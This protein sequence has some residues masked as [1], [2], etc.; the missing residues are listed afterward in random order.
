[1]AHKFMAPLQVLDY[2]I[3]NRPLADTLDYEITPHNQI[4]PNFQIPIPHLL[5]VPLL[6]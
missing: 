3:Y 5:L 2:C 4:W 6:M 1:M